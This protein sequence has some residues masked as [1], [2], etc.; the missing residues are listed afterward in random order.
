M[1]IDIAKLRKLLAEAPAFPT[2]KS[3][4]HGGAGG[5]LV[6]I[7]LLAYF[8]CQASVWIVAHICSKGDKP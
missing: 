6:T 8:P 2:E 3:V 5:Q 7:I 1:T 4:I